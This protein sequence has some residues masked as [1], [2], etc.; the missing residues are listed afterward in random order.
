[1]NAV[2]RV[3][4]NCRVCGSKELTSIMSLGDLY[5]SDFLDSPDNDKGIK[6]PLELVLCDA[7][8]GGCG[9]LQLKHTVSPEAMYGNYWYRSGINK[10]MTDELNNIAG[11]VAEIADLKPGDYVI[12]IGAND[13]TLLRGYKIVGLN[14]VG[15]EPAKNLEQY[16]KE[17]TTKIIVDFFNQPAWQKEFGEAKA[18][19]ITA[20]AMFY[21]LDD[22]NSFVSDVV[23][24]LDDDGVFIIQMM[25]LPPFLKRN[26]FDGICHEH[27]EYYSLFSLEN[28]LKRHGLEI[29]DAEMREHINEGSVRVYVKKSGKGSALKIKD[30][31]ADRVAA[32]RRKESELGL[33][34]KQTYNALVG[35]ILE[36]KEKAVSFIK[37]E[38]AKGRKIHGYAAST[39]GNTTLQFY[40]FTPD[41]I[42][43]VADR[44]PQKWGKF[45]VGTLIPIIS[46][47]ESRARKPDYY[48]I[49]AWHFLPE[50]INRELEYLK[51]G[52]KFIVPLPEFKIISYEQ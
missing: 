28:L 23:K 4:N 43:A 42:E 31:A 19:A 48:F 37:Q 14:T 18:K 29:F 30:G 52:G 8:K 32:L 26:A 45:T 15:F 11:K 3:I 46:E 7:K 5:V 17:G 35:R 36:A 25:Y 2:S 22:P 1:M 6:A 24:C 34:D 49:L 27:L 16:G 39:K 41:L 40:G 44:N 33:G 13:G 50:F 38:V 12:D 51:N 21:D 47:E 10:T 20:I 9:L